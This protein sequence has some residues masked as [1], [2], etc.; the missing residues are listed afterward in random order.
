MPPRFQKSHLTNQ[1]SFGEL[2]SSVSPVEQFKPSCFGSGAIEE[3]LGHDALTREAL[4]MEL[5]DKTRDSKAHHK[6]R[7]KSKPRQVSEKEKPTKKPSKN[8]MRFTTGQMYT[9]FIF[10]ISAGSII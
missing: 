7:E 3:F 5:L 4:M 1:G 9:I 6:P 2:P 10:K 8:P